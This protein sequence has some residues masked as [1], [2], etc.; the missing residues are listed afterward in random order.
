[1]WLQVSW[2]GDGTV[3]DL[4]PWEVYSADVDED[5][6]KDKLLGSSP[7]VTVA[8]RRLEHKCHAITVKVCP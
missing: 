4:S 8:C 6:L 2:E 3:D 7:A 1:M 5:S